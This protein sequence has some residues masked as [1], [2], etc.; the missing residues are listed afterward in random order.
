MA[1]L[2]DSCINQ[3]G[4][5]T[6]DIWTNQYH[7][8]PDTS[9]PLT[10]INL[11]GLTERRKIQRHWYTNTGH[12]HARTQT[13]TTACTHARPPT[14]MHTHTHTHTPEACPVRNW[15]V[16]LSSYP[17]VNFVSAEPTGSQRATPS[18]QHE[19]FPRGL[20]GWSTDDETVQRHQS[21]QEKYHTLHSFSPS[22]FFNSM[23]FIGIAVH[24]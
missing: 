22:L 13:H 10:D 2:S 24:T 21:P 23:I 1:F 5:S 18:P 7:S 9:H 12:M 16:G 4:H 15:T 17:G 6:L 14:H 11:W 20:Q 19:R 3:C 8:N